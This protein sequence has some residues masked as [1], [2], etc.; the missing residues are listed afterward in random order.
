MVSSDCT[1]DDSMAGPS[2]AVANGTN[3]VHVEH[4]DSIAGPS[5]AVANGANG[6]TVQAEVHDTPLMLPQVINGE[7]Y[8]QAFPSL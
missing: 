8:S 1:D 3:G 2:G 6:I 7:F 5:H 4:Q